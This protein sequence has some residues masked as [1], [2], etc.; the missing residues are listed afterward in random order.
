V[1]AIVVITIGEMITFPT[2]RVLAVSF[3]PAEMRGRYMAI[4]DLGWTLPA[5]FGPAAAGLI[6]DNYDPNLLWYV[7]GILCLISAACFYAL[8]FW[9]GKQERFAPAP[10]KTEVSRS[11]KLEIS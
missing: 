10:V 9:L 3:A 7:G 11:G 6:L 1:L 4:Y 5:T 8:H 2:N